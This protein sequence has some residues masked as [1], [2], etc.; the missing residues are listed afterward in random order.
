MKKTGYILD[1]YA[2]LAYLQ[3]EH[4]GEQVRDILQE[5]ASHRATAWL[6]VISLGEIFYIT[7][8][9]RGESE[10]REIVGDISMLPAELIPA[11]I[12]RV[13]AA[14]RIKAQHPISY[15]DAFVVAA[16]V[17]FKATITTGD[18]EFKHIESIASVL[19]L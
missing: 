15:A 9:K 5:A 8:R 6:S 2:V 4:G 19:W 13:L 18:P 17:E 7:V 12:E 14:A 10:A 3:A 16:A 11:D 1:S